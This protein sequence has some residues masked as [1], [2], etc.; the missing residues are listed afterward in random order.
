MTCVTA[1]VLPTDVLDASELEYQNRWYQRAVTDRFFETEGFR[2]LVSWNL[3]AFRRAVRPRPHMTMLSLGCGLGDYEIALARDVRHVT[4]VDFCAPAIAGANARAQ[5]EG[6]TNVTFVAAPFREVVFPD[7]TFDVV[8]ALG[9]LHHM[10]DR[11][12]RVD[13]LSKACRWLKPDGKVYVREPSRRGLVPRIAYR[14]FRERHDLH[15]PN[16]EHLDPFVVQSELTAAGFSRLEVD[17]TDVIGGPLPWLVRSRSRLFWS[18]VFGF[19][20]AWL[21]VPGLRQLASQFAIT[22]F[23]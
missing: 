8:Y 10:P 23:K 18:A 7:E 11:Q 1:P 3:A 14:F 17:Y 6:V 21:A 13:V 19:D 9:V 20:R 16:E 2:R 15:S 4:G 22:G 12:R 5:Q